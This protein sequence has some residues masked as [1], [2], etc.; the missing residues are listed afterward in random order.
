MI[1]PSQHILTF[2]HGPIFG[3]SQQKEQNIFFTMCAANF[4]R[5]FVVE[6]AVWKCLESCRES[7]RVFFLTEIVKLVK[8]TVVFNL[9]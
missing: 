4:Q 9:L 1:V 7:V 2:D 5:M 8:H 3:N 6:A